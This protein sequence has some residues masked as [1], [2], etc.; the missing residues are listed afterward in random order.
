MIVVC[1]R[2]SSW[3]ASSTCPLISF[4]SGL[5][6]M[7]IPLVKR[8]VQWATHF[9]EVLFHLHLQV[10]HGAIRLSINPYGLK[11]YHVIPTSCIRWLASCP[12]AQGVAERYKQRNDFIYIEILFTP[13]FKVFLFGYGFNCHQTASFSADGIV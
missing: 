11:S 2:A 3:E 7:L 10:I 9:P 5:E 4:D 13:R 6:L 12:E 1:F 8:E